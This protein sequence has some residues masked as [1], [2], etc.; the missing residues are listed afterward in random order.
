MPKQ[1]GSDQIGLVAIGSRIIAVAREVAQQPFRNLR[2][3]FRLYRQS[4]HGGRDRH[5]KQLN[6]QVHLIESR[7]HIGVADG[8]GSEFSWRRKFSAQLLTQ[9]T[10]VEALHGG[11]QRQFPFGILQ[12]I[13]LL[14]DRAL[15][16]LFLVKPKG[17]LRAIGYLVT[18]VGALL[19]L[20]AS[21]L[22]PFSVLQLTTEKP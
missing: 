14:K 16:G 22:A 11:Q 8:V 17:N 3:K 6:P 18:E 9:Q 15:I 20:V 1:K 7:A 13:P 10:L 5:V 2:I 12:Q 19:P 21:G 4:Q